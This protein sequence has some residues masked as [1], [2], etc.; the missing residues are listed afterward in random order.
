MKTRVLV[1]DDDRGMRDML[2]ARLTTRGFEVTLAGSGAEAIDSVR[3]R[4]LDVVVSD[5]NMKGIDG[6][7][8]CRRLLEHR[9]H[10]C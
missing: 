9:P 10:R 5:I 1:V 4:D 7:E 3:D 2:C 6:V 8:L